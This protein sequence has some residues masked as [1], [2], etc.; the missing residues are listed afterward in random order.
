MFTD[1]GIRSMALVP[2]N[3]Y[4]EFERGPDKGFGIRVRAASKSFFVQYQSP[5]TGKRR[6]LD[7]GAYPETTL[8]QARAACRE[9]R[10]LVEAGKDPQIERDKAQEAERQQLLEDERRKAI[11]AATGTVADL[12]TAYFAKLEREGK[13]SLPELRRLY[14][15]EI[16]TAIGS[17]K[18]R[19]IVVDDAREII[20]TV[21]ARGAHVVANRVRELL[22]AAFRYG[23]QADN[24]VTRD[25]PAR[26]RLEYNPVTAIPKPTKVQAGERALGAEEIRDLWHALEEAGMDH[27]TKCIARLMLLTGQRVQEVVGMRWGEL[28]EG[29]TLW[30]L[31]PDRTKNER[32]HLVPLSATAA[33]I[34]A[35]MEPIS[36]DKAHVFPHRDR[37]DLPMEWRSVSRAIK[38][39]CDK[40]TIQPFTPKDLRRT[41]RTRAGEAGL[42]KEIRDRIQNHALHDVSS[43]HY[44]RFDYLEPKRVA[45]LK[46]ERWLLAAIDGRADTNVVP[47][48]KSA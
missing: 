32:A 39:F 23:L 22:H 11:E 16:H 29:K 34:V 45:L 13:R 2:G 17:K 3:G 30:T 48:A 47:L 38:R 25:S 41:W 33:Q 8:S 26:F 40:A 43:R 44:D 9:A 24:D 20:R 12:F 10:A 6:F 31:P 46:W 14:E 1:K 36:G 28:D 15:K 27:A 42:S 7:L 5:I 19:D 35:T 21:Y 37:E 4:R 18:A